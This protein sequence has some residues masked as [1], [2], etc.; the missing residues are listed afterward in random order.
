MKKY[1]YI[2]SHL[3]F[4]LFFWIFLGEIIN[5][6]SVV[7]GTVVNL[8]GYPIIG[9]TI[10]SENDTVLTDFGGAFKIKESDAILVVVKGCRT[11]TFYPPF[12]NPLVIM[13]K[14]P[15]YQSV[16]VAYA[17]QNRF[18][19]TSAVSSATAEEF[20]DSYVTN[21][22]SS[23]YGKLSGLTV[24][25][26]TGEPGN[27]HPSYL[28]RGLGTL[29]NENPLVFVDGLEMSMNLLKLEEIESISVL[30]DAAALAPFGI[31]GANGI[32]WVSTKRGIKGTPIIK[33]SVQ[34]GIQ[35]PVKLPEFVDAYD[36]ARLYNE[37]RSNDNGNIWSPFYSEEQ[38]NAYKN[39]NDG[40]IANYDL[41]YPNVNWYD[42]VLKS[43]APQYNADFSVSGGND[44]VLYYLLL[45]YQFS[46]GLYSDTDFKRN[47]NSNNDY[48]KVNVRSNVD[49]ELPSIFDARVTF[50]GVIDNRYTPSYTV[51]TLWQNMAKY[52]A[53]AFPVETPEGWGEHPYILTIQ[54]LR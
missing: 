1:T 14:D 11:Q 24:I 10:I 32:I 31:K 23:L 6:Q 5:A 28:I 27:D 9:A 15:I 18:G 41:L 46:G 53:N 7:N 21:I 36:Y 42:E 13:E 33:A 17:S 50:G 44:M 54:K 40:S 12:D 37:A 45:G 22:G 16:D 38:L 4:Y 25:P 34:T 43:S 35:Q 39:G 8:S 2:Y 3:V 26:S 29:N 48:K 49:I 52:P 47:L 20:K 30:K 19:L 51:T